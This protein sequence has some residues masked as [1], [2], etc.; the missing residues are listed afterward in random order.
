M[1]NFMARKKKQDVVAE[2]AVNVT[3]TENTATCENCGSTGV[4]CYMCNGNEGFTAQ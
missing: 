1:F 3:Q 4:K 2:D